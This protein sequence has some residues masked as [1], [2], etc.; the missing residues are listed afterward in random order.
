[1]RADGTLPIDFK[2]KAV[3]RKRAKP[4]DAAPSQNSVSPLDTQPEI[5]QDDFTQLLNSF[6]E[7]LDA[8][9]VGKQQNKNNKHTKTH[10]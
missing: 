4:T 10:D 8:I 1:M 2:D 7:T 3:K 9:E 5:R 6:N